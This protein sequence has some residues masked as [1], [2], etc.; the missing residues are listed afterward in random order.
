ML[1]TA[2][3]QHTSSPLF[4][5]V[6]VLDFP[7]SADCPELAAALALPGVVRPVAR[8]SLGPAMH[9]VVQGWRPGHD[10]GTGAMIGP[11]EYAA[12]VRRLFDQVLT[13]GVPDGPHVVIDDSEPS[14]ERTA[15]VAALYPDACLV[16][17]AADLPAA[18][19][20]ASRAPAATAA[21]SGGPALAESKL[22]VIIGCARSGTTWLEHLLMAHPDAG[23]V[24][25]AES[26]VFFDLRK[27]WVL[28]TSSAVAAAVSRDSARELL[29]GHCD[30]LFGA[31]LAARTPDRTHFVEKTPLHSMQ[32]PMIN[33]LYP[34]AAMIHLLRDGRDVAR[35]LAEVEFF[36]H[37]DVRQGATL[38]REVIKRVRQDSAQVRRFREVRYEALT[39]DP[40]GGT[41]DILGWLGLSVSDE[42][43]ADIELRAGRRVS[44]H[45]TTG[46]VGSGKWSGLTD[47][48]VAQIYDAAGDE[49]VQEGYLDPAELR[50]VRRSKAG[51][52]ARVTRR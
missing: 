8:S 47:L 7:E 36:D 6:V 22:V 14:T 52:R 11:D 25:R 20:A 23:G 40:V 4:Q 30:A 34:D 3:A 45:G 15:A 24:E 46:E 31:S 2:P 28:L 12:L 27:L 41:Q 38:W 33:E 50:R 37:V 21:A 5:R 42:V 39:A 1:T 13:L 9:Q 32:M 51:L 44:V 29:R 26:F 18:V 35:S 10:E 19:E 49:L 16:R 48:Q 43:R 17:A